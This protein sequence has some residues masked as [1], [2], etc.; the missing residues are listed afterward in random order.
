M[1]KNQEKPKSPAIPTHLR[2]VTRKGVESFWRCG[3][4]FTNQPTLIA[5]NDLAQADCERLC[6]EPQLVCQSVVVETS[7]STQ[8]TAE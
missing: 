2:V 7:D 1:S 8:G 6:A 3:R 5:L 4:R